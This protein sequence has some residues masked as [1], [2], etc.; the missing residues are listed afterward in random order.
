MADI[1]FG[2]SNEGAAIGKWLSGP[3]TQQDSSVSSMFETLRGARLLKR[4]PK[5]LQHPKRVRLPK[6]IGSVK[7]RTREWGGRG[8]LFSFE[9]FI[10]S[11]AICFYLRHRLTRQM[12]EISWEAAVLI[13]LNVLLALIQMAWEFVWQWWHYTILLKQTCS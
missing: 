11:Y 3:M 1:S 9:L 10:S 13:K 4:H 5:L 2:A 12:P 7:V 6:N 8:F